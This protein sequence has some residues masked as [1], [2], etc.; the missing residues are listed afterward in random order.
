MQQFYRAYLMG[1]MVVAGRLARFNGHSDDSSPHWRR[2]GR[3]VIRRILGAAM[4]TVPL[5][6]AAIH[7]DPAGNGLSLHLGATDLTSQR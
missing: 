7:P 4:R 3:M 6:A 5:L 2:V 1:F